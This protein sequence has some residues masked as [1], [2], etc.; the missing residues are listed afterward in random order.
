MIPL[1]LA[2]FLIVASLGVLVLAGAILWYAFI[3]SFTVATHDPSDHFVAPDWRLIRQSVLPTTAEQSASEENSTV[4]NDGFADR[5]RPVDERIKRLAE[6][7]NAQFSRNPGDET[8]FT[9][10]YPRRLLEAWALEQSGLPPDFQADYVEELIVVSQAI[11]R[12]PQI[13][14]IGSLDD[15]AQ[16]IMNAL[17]A[18]RTAYLD[19]LEQ[20]QSRASPSNADA[21]AHCEGAVQRSTYLGLGGLALLLL[22]ALIVILFRIETHL[23]NQSHRRA[24]AQAGRQSPDPGMKNGG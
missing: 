20:A 23:R 2:A 22:L 9:D 10:R 8:G 14:R 3:H 18:F 21:A 17:D 13:N 19:Q 4:R 11:G 7:L 16:A 1:R 6:N 12:D 15:R 5:R 24:L